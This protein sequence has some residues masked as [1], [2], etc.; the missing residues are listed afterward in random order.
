MIWVIEHYY[1][2]EYQIGSEA[3]TMI[4]DRL[5][6]HLMQPEAGFI[7][8]HIVNTSSS[9]SMEEIKNEMKDMKQSVSL[10]RIILTYRLMKTP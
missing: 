2:V 3:I 7:A 5:N 6:C 8:M 9:C 10:Y 4:N 1:P